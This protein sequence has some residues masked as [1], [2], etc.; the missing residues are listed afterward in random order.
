MLDNYGTVPFDM[1]KITYVNRPNAGGGA[2]I[3]D[4]RLF[5]TRNGLKWYE[6]RINPFIG[7]V[8]ID[9]A[10]RV[11]RIALMFDGLGRRFLWFN[12][13]APFTFNNVVGNFRDVERNVAQ[14]EEL[15]RIANGDISLSNIDH[16]VLHIGIGNR[17]SISTYQH[18]RSFAIANGSN[19]RTY[20]YL[21]P[22]THQIAQTSANPSIEEIRVIQTPQGLDENS[23]FASSVAYSNIVFFSSGNVIY[24]LDFSTGIATEIYRHPGGGEIVAMRM[25]RQEPLLAGH[26]TDDYGHPIDRS[27]G[28]AVNIGSIGELVVL[29][30]NE[31]G[32]VVQS[33]IFRGFGQ[34][35][36]IHF[37]CDV[38]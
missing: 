6:A 20:I 21:F 8:R 23:R 4:G 27:L 26:D 13:F 31:A 37:V 38:R 30:L 16:Q 24:H 3:N 15:D 36:D 33:E 12:Y 18:I 19:S 7:D 17:A 32:V 28:V 1:S 25:A 34:I 5:H 29:N 2:I 9:H 14:I 35:K 10:L 11:G 22:T